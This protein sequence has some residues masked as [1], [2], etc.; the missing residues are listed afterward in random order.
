MPQLNR[1][2]AFSGMV[3]PDSS[4]AWK[5]IFSFLGRHTGEVRGRSSENPA[6]LR[7]RLERFAK[8]EIPDAEIDELCSEIASSPDAMEIFARLLRKEEKNPPE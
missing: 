7:R 3:H 6:D 5:N 8:G 1:V 2:A 4:T